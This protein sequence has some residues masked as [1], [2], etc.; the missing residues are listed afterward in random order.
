MCYLMYCKPTQTRLRSQ[1]ASLV[2][3][4]HI[5]SSLLQA[6]NQQL[7]DEMYYLQ[8]SFYSKSNGFIQ[9]TLFNMVE[10]TKV[11]SFRQCYFFGL[12]VKIS[13][14]YSVCDQMYTKCYNMCLHIIYLF[15]FKCYILILYIL[16]LSYSHQGCIF[17]IKNPFKIF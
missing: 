3:Y 7:V 17:L 4:K 8:W 6:W 11:H 16:I 5:R 15:L 13:S 12:K 9:V 14:F 2:L 1:V 10:S